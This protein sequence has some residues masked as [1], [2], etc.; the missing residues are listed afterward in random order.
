MNFIRILCKFAVMAALVMAVVGIGLLFW[1]KYRKIESLS[2]RRTQL[3]SAMALHQ[4]TL[5]DIKRRQE[6]FATDPEFVERVA[7]QNR[8]ARPGELVFVT[9]PDTP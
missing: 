2:Q 5:H 7:R 4:A 6:R 8:R 3:Q 1:P 9:E